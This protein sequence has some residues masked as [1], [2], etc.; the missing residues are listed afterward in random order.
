[1]NNP[2]RSQPRDTERAETSQGQVHVFL[3]GLR[4]C[5]PSGAKEVSHV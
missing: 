4:V 5:L 3:R 2:N 1:M